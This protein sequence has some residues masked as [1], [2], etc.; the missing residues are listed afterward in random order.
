MGWTAVESLST[1]GP[2]NTGHEELKCTDCHSPERGTLRQQIQ[3]SLDHW[4]GLRDDIVYVGTRPVEST[5]CLACHDR[6]TD[7]H[8]IYR[9]REPRFAEAREE[10]GADQ[11]LSCHG[12]HSGVR[13]TQEQ[14]FCQTCH[15][16]LE[17]KND[18]IDVPHV[19]L[20]A[21][22]NWTSCLTCHDFHGNHIYDVP[23]RMG[24]AFTESDVA[25]YLRGEQVL[26]SE[27]RKHSA[28]TSLP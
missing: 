3:G 24:D 21:K 14:G 5:P 16:G 1:P 20:I 27:E 7:R 10:I 25:A 2:M 6:P 9:F 11:C 4:R 28:R 23:L 15:D 13:V 12:E 26:Y 22:N 18:P 8:P 19:D 17:M